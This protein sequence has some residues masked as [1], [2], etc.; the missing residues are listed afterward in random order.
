MIS[1]NFVKIGLSIGS[2][3]VLSLKEPAKFE[4]IET[5]KHN[6]K[7]TFDLLDRSSEALQ[8]Y[9]RITSEDQVSLMISVIPLESRVHID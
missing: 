6:K 4:H 1:C 5:L 3:I 2:R 9:T 8:G 7:Q